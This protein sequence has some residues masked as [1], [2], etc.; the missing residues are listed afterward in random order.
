MSVEIVGNFGPVGSAGTEGRVADTQMGEA[1]T[2]G[3]V[4]VMCPAA[5]E[6]GNVSMCEADIVDCTGRM[7]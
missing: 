4:G 2:L 7:Y 5:S 1:D 6:G 3:S